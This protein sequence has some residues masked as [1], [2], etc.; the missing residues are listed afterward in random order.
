MSSTEITVS[1]FG[2]SC[3]KCER[4]VESRIDQLAGVSWSKAD[5]TQNS[6]CVTGT[7]LLDEIQEQILDLGYQLTQEVLV[8]Q[9]PESETLS[10]GDIPGYNLAVSGMSC[11]SCVRSVERA[12]MASPGVLKATVNYAGGTAFVKSSG[13]L[14]GLLTA[15]KDAGYPGCLQSDDLDEQEQRVKSDFSVAVK[16]SGNH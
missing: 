12:L 16:K 3:S 5:F 9:E 8:A 11:A 10:Y 13:A 7:V 1:V 15:L 4:K 14:E 2:M 6:L